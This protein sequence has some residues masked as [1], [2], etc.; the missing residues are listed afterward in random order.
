[1]IVNTPATAIIDGISTTNVIYKRNEAETTN[2]HF[3]VVSDREETPLGTIS[4]TINDD[5]VG[6]FIKPIV[7]H[8][9]AIYEITGVASRGDMLIFLSKGFERGSIKSLKD[10]VIY[11]TYVN[12]DGSF[13]FPSVV[14]KDGTAS[15]WIALPTQ[16]IPTASLSYELSLIDY[17][18]SIGRCISNNFSVLEEDYT[19]TKPF[20]TITGVCSNDI[21]KIYISAADSGSDVPCLME[22]MCKSVVPSDDGTYEIKCA[23]EYGQNYVLWAITKTYGSLIIDNMVVSEDTTTCLS[24]DTMITMADGTERR[25]DSLHVGDIVL[26]ESGTKSYVREV[27]SGHF[28]NYHTL[29]YF[30]DGTVINETHPHR[31]YNVDQGFWQRLQLWNIGDHALNRNGEAVALVSVE[32]IDEEIEMFGIWVDKGTYYANGLLSGEA[33]CNKKLLEEASA[34]KAVDMMLSTDEDW[35]LQLMGLDGELP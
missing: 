19:Y 24:A 31:F 21:D 5:V 10:N 14:C 28:S 35:L 22:N 4:L 27:Y 7:L 2:G 13:K 1:M 16:D 33:S 17:D 12:S 34:E 11:T 8:E 32:K 15:L 26:S 20:F 30:E 3:Y 23:G 18:S 9:A 29:Y 6:Y 25:M